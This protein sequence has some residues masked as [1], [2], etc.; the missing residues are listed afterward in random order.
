MLPPGQEVQQDSLDSPEDSPDELHAPSVEPEPANSASEPIPAPG[1]SL[2]GTM[3]TAIGVVGIVL[4]IVIG[5]LGWRLIGDLGSAAEQSL[6]LSGAA[7]TTIDRTI[8]VVRETVGTLGDGL[9]TVEGSLGDASTTLENA[10]D[11]FDVT[12]DVAATD[13]PES[14]ASVRE[15]LPPLIS[16]AESITDAIG[17]L[18]IFGINTGPTQ[19]LAEPIIEIETNLFQLEE[20]LRTQAGAIT[21]IASD[22]DTFSGDA[23]DLANNVGQMNRDLAEAESLLADYETTTANARGAIETTQAEVVR[24]VSTAR[25][26]VIV[27]AIMF[28]LSQAA[29][30]M[31][32]RV[33]RS[34]REIG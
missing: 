18:S 9:A 34:G 22:F 25:A 4:S 27:L 6:N 15:A 32:G 5:I 13:L 19:P 29:P 2:A 26:T 11:L 16:S 23:R 20:R 33:L 17:A 30:I 3:L 31:M 10:S 24:T 12:A 28:G 1:P 14:I 8:V 7:L 21:E